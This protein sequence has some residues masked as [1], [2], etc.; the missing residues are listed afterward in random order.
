M[1]IE[2]KWHAHN[3]VSI[4]LES[5]SP[6]HRFWG[7]LTHVDIIEFSK[8]LWQLKNQGHGDKIVCGFSI[9]LILTGVIIL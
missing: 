3:F 4:S 5:L 7:A 9:I 8:F 6:G 1:I 2:K